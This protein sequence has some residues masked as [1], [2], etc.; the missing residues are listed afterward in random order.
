ML[1]FARLVVLSCSELKIISSSRSVDFI[2]SDSCSL[3]TSQGSRK[4]S[5]GSSRYGNKPFTLL[6]GVHLHGICYV[7]FISFDVLLG[8]GCFSFYY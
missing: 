8:S 1:S 2:P 4:C 6:S 7:I 5:L 3:A